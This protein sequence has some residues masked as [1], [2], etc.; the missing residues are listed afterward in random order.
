MRRLDLTEIVAA[1]SQS[2]VGVNVAVLIGDIFPDGI[3]I[4]VVKQKHRAVNPLAGSFVHFVEQNAGGFVV[5]D[6]QRGGLAVL[7]FDAV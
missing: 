2:V 7:D 3:V 4:A 1:I 5:G 6:L